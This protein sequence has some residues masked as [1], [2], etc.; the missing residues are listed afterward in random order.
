M[1]PLECE[2]HG[3]GETWIVCV[4]AEPGRTAARLVEDPQVSGDV[5]CDDCKKA[6]SVGR[7]VEKDLRLSCGACVRSLYKIEGAS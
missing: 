5:L 7:P 3:A 4:H 2:T 1:S 6:C